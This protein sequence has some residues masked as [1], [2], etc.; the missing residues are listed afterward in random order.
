VL[1][2]VTKSGASRVPRYLNGLTAARVRPRPPPL[3][4]KPQTLGEHFINPKPGAT[5]HEL[6]H[7][8][9]SP[10]EFAS[11]VFFESAQGCFCP[12][13]TT[14]MP[15]MPPRSFREGRSEQ[16]CFGTLGASSKT[17]TLVPRMNANACVKDVRRPW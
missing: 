3:E 7:V 10:D 11:T 2:D 6:E 8:Y 16:G 4:R 13:L 12:S 17:L 15:D 9:S 5:A 14:S 1:E